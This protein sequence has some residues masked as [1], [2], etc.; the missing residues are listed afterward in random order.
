[1]EDFK[2]HKLDLHISE[3]NVLMERN[4][5]YLNVQFVMISGLIIWLTSILP[6]IFENPTW[7]YLW[8]GTLLFQGYEII[9]MGLIQGTYSIIKYLEISLKSDVKQLLDEVGGDDFWKYELYNKKTRRIQPL[10]WEIILVLISSLT[11]PIVFCVRLIICWD[12]TFDS[13]GL[14]LNIALLII[15]IKQSRSVI[16]TRKS[17]HKN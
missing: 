2:R 9:I 13:I 17:F 5:Y 3:Y 15:L 8:G 12:N 16:S 10:I 1:M 7:Y 11:V 6:K 4:T 14:L